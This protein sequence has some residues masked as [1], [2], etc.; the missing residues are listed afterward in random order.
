MQYSSCHEASEERKRR[1]KITN[2]NGKKMSQKQRNLRG[3]RDVAGQPKRRRENRWCRDVNQENFSLPLFSV[4]LSFTHCHARLFFPPFNIQYAFRKLCDRS[5]GRNSFQAEKVSVGD[6]FSH[7][8]CRR[9][10][11]LFSFPIVFSVS[12]AHAKRRTYKNV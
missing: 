5:R 11:S 12:A 2:L 1:K 7:S 6:V 3:V 10:G 8:Q 4:P 9:A